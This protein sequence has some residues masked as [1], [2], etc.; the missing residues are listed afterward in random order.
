MQE[1]SWVH[2]LQQ[3]PPTLQRKW[4]IGRLQSVSEESLARFGTSKAA[5]SI[6]RTQHHNWIFKRGGK[7]RKNFQKTVSEQQASSNNDLIPAHLSVQY[8]D[9]RSVSQIQR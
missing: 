3:I 6:T 9:S 8:R 7:K 1:G 4:R 5:F 2:E